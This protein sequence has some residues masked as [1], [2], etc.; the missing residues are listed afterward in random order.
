LKLLPKYVTT[1]ERLGLAMIEVA[2]RGAPKRILESE[3]IN[4]L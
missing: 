4:S 2:R 3:D 1:T